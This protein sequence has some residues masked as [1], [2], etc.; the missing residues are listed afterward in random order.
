MS[1]LGQILLLFAI[2][3]AGDGISAV[4]PFPFPGSVLSMLLLLG[5]LACRAVK[6]K[7]LKEGAG[8]LL[9]NMAVFF[10]PACVGI[11]RYTEVLFANFWSIVLISL[12][13]TPLVFFVT[14]HAVQLT[15]KLMKKGGKADA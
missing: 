8:F 12:L 13:T 5:L 11:L 3:L 9:D 14:G 4:L 2:C 7:D 15:M 6:P 10:V 1:S